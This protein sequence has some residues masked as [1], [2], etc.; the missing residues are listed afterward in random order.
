MQKLRL[1]GFPRRPRP[2][3][4]PC[5]PPAPAAS[6][7]DAQH[8]VQALRH[9]VL[10]GPQTPAGCGLSGRPSSDQESGAPVSCALR[11]RAS[12][13]EW[14]PE[15]LL[16]APGCPR[17]AGPLEHHL[18][19]GLYSKPRP[20]GQLCSRQTEATI[21]QAPAGRRAIFS[22][23]PLAVPLACTRGTCH[24]TSWHVRFPDNQ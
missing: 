19:Q 1:S 5:S 20:T 14:I 7:P 3:P 15:L 12:R 6:T 4:G 18:L 2:G 22:L 9:A 13:G 8:T 23:P 16:S 17:L 21:G 24:V 11:P 10:S